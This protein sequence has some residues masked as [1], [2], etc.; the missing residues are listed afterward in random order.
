ML[1]QVL[2]MTPEQIAALDATQQA[3][4]MQLVSLRRRAWGYRLIKQRAQFLG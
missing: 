1:M 4:I 2:S 3:S